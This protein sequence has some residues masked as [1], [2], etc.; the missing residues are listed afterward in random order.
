MTKDIYLKSEAR[1]KFPQLVD[2][3][4]ESN[5]P[6]YIYNR[7]VPQA[8]LISISTYN[9][10]N[11]TKPTKKSFKESGLVGIWK[12]R[13]DMKDSVAWVN[14]IRQEEGTDEY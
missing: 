10:L 13:E 14:K 5:T 3:V 1:E 12:D 11:T 7:D 8:V 6:I 9:S 4:Y 2:R